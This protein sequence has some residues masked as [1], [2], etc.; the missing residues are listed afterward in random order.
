MGS[1]DGG[2]VL[3]PG[4]GRS[5]TYPRGGHLEIKVGGADTAG[6]YALLE[7][8]IPPGGTGSPLH[9]HLATEETLYLVE[10]ELTVQLGE[11]T[12]RAGAG[13]CILVPR[14]VAH[15]FRNTGA[16]RARLL[17]LIS[18]ADFEAY[19]LELADLM[20]ASP[21]GS[22]DP[23]TLRSVA[24]RHGQRFVDQPSGR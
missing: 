2:I 12:T 17:I 1:E 14:G 21:D 5:L 4:G 10:G 9:Y 19:F 16:Q 18:P 11:R 7:F 8:T 24:T 3:A 6:A 22:L 20:R 23:E 13:S 15:T